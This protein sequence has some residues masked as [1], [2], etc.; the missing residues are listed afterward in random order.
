MRSPEKANYVLFSTL[1]KHQ[2]GALE[3][4]AKSGISRRTRHNTSYSL[5]FDEKEPKDWPTAYHCLS[6]D[7]HGHGKPIAGPTIATTTT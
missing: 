6:I 3:I 2:T 4:L 5:F 7:G 1:T